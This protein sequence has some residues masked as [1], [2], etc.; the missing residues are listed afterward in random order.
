MELR[1]DRPVQPIQIVAQIVDRLRPFAYGCNVSVDLSPHSEWRSDVSLKVLC[2][3]QG[4]DLL[5]SK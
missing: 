4:R 5:E 2:V 1:R 3:W